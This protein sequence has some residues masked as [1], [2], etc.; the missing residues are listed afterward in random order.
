VQIERLRRFC[1]PLFARRYLSAASRLRDIEQLEQIASGYSSRGRFISE[2]TLDPPISTGDLAGAPLLDEDYVTLST[3]HSAKGC[4]WDVVHVIQAVDGMIPSD[5]ATGHADGVEEE[6]RLFYVA[7][8]RARDSLYVY[9]PLHYYDR[10]RGLS[11]R[12]SYAQ[13]TRFIPNSVRVL[14]DER[15]AATDYTIAIGPE[16]QVGGDPHHGVEAYL[17]QLWQG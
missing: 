6:R 14:F 7:L 10:G 8:T 15:N 5:M 9:C 11:D 17:Q 3:I 13:I 12:H 2:L 4:E 16:S 1:E